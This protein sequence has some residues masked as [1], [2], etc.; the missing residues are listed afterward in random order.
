MYKIKKMCWFFN[1]WQKII[2][3]V[4]SL[5]MISVLVS[6]T[7]TG[8]QPNTSHWESDSI[9]HWDMRQCCMLHL[10]LQVF[11]VEFDFISINSV[12]FSMKSFLAHCSILPLWNSLAESRRRMYKL[13]YSPK[14]ETVRYV[15]W[16]HMQD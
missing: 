3:A 13:F 7:H 4:S 15:K 11:L 9:S 5:H 16:A 2:V 8:W 14:M 1:F 10:I 6:T 12:H